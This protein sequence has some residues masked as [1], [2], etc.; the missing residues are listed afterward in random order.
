MNLSLGILGVYPNAQG[1]NQTFAD[2]THPQKTPQPVIFL[3]ETKILRID[4]AKTA[5]IVIDMQND[6][7][8]PDGCLSHY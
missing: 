2:I 1:V 8:Q 3:T 6:F 7:C 4:L 5:I